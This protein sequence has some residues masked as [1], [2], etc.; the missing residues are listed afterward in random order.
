MSCS[1]ENIPAGLL[2]L[3]H[4]VGQA[5]PLCLYLSVQSR[6]T[7]NCMQFCPNGTRPWGFREVA[8]VGWERLWERGSSCTAMG[9][10]PSML[11]KIFQS[12]CFRAPTLLTIAL[13]LC[14]IR[15]PNKLLGSPQQTV[16]IELRLSLGLSKEGVDLN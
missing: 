16:R 8:L 13:H 6:L 14:S 10:P 3:S 9:T 12:S 15:R 5:E 11:V 2:T 4:R 1:Q 7:V